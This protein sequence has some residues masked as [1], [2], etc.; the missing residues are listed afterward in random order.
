[1]REF[2]ADA[3]TTV[4]PQTIVERFGSWNEAK[5]K[6]GLVPRRFATRADLLGLLRASSVRS[7]AGR[8]R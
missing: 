1:M 4:H 6:A 3:Q 8:R 5:R 2:A 7:S